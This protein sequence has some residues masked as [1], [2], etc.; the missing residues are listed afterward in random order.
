MTIIQMPDGSRWK[1]STSTDMVHCVHCDN[2][3]D[4][5]EEIASYPDG[6]CPDCNNSWT[7]NE[8]RSTT[9]VVTAPEAIKG[10]T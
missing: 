3:V 6:T 4:T 5:P 10:D 7:G 2:A 9:I 1:P 8:R